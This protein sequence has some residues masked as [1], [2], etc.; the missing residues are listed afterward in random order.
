[1]Q[2]IAPDYSIQLIHYSFSAD[3]SQTTVTFDVVNSG[4]DSKKSSTAVLNLIETGEQIATTPVPALVSN[5]RYT[6]VMTFSNE[7]F[8]PGSVESFRAVVGVGDVEQSGSASVQ[9]NF[10]RIVVTLPSTLP[11]PQVTP[12]I[13]TTSEATSE[14]ASSGNDAVQQ[15]LQTLN[16]DLSKPEQKALL[17]GLVAVVLVLALII[18]VILRLLFARKP[19][20]SGWQPSYANF[21]PADPNTLA[22]RRQQWQG[23][24]QN[25]SLAQSGAEGTVQVRKMPAGVDDHYLSG[26]RI[27]AVRMSQY[28][29]YG[30]VNRSQITPSQS[31]VK[32]LDWIARK[33]EKLNADQLTRQLN[34]VA[35]ALSRE[36]RKKVNDRT[37][38]LPL[39][40]DIRLRARHGEVR[41]WFE[42][43]RRQYGQWAQIDRWEPEMMVQGKWMYETFTYSLY[44][45][46]AGE[47]LKNF[48]KRLENDL[49]QVLTEMF[50]PYVIAAPQRPDAPTDPHLMPV[51]VDSPK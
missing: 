48:Q 7:R 10:A 42:L 43:Y 18:W 41:I 24:A 26:W 33:H 1:M 12:Q 49:L 15:V 20:F 29:M 8:A 5:G 3:N 44:G 40:I 31:I 21:L 6:V 11:Q 14:P 34:P 25:S 50:N 32:R 19:D 2:D 35:R 36:V 39:A 23:V 46:K 51:V 30:R 13:E 27:V 4:G 47:D 38:M 9:D 17:I 28:D 37:A 22:G 16:L 45:Q